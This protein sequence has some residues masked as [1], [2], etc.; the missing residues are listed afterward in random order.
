MRDDE[1]AV[2]VADGDVFTELA[3][4]FRTWPK[5]PSVFERYARRGEAGEVV[6]LVARFGGTAIGYCLVE[7][8]SSYPPFAS[9]GIPE[10]VDL[11]VL[12]DDQGRGAGRALM[13]AAEQLVAT[14]SDHA[15]LRM[16]LYSDYGRAQ[17]I[18]A[19]RGY[20]PDGAGVSVNGVVVPPG[21][22]IVLDDEPVLALILA[23]R[24]A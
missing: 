7:W 14:R 15:G 22:T 19:R 8:C 9:A 13:D 16:G 2:V 21:S 23:L 5:P 10:I 17:R 24:N 20:V 18:Y 1:V 6:V 4:A 3:A 11:N 12:R